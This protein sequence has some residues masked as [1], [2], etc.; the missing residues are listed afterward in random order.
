MQL[1]MGSALETLC[2][3]A[4]GAGQYHMLGVYLQRAWLVLFATC[5][6]LSL[7]FVYMA[8]VLKLVGQDAEIAEK[9]G[10]YAVY[11][12]PSLFGA[13]LLQPLVK[14]LQT[15]SVVIPMLLCAATA[16][17][18]HA[19]ILYTFIYT[20]HWGFRGAAMATSVSFWIN[21]ILLILYIKL[22]AVCDRTWKGF[23]REAFADLSEFLQLA[24]PSCVMI[25]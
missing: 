2:G 9:A 23:S 8:D 21:G 25:W 18:S 15:Q 5:V 1:G 6:P 10:E 3:Q 20:L 7:A 16:L 14:F 12:L 22:S 11:L 17:V 4:H 13:A 19:A 24:I